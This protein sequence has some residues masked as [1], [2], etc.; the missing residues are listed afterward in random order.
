MKELTTL[1]ASAKASGIT[2]AV[3]SDS[4]VPFLILESS[5][6]GYYALDHDPFTNTFTVQWVCDH[7]DNLTGLVW[8]GGH[9]PVE[10][11]TVAGVM[12]F[13]KELPVLKIA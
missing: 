8:C 2:I 3:D 12:E 11:S 6:G 5:V 1:I 13:I 7:I 9:L 10:F 4:F